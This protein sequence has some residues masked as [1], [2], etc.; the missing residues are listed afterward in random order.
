MNICKNTTRKIFKKNKIVK[1]IAL[2]L[3]VSAGFNL[4]I[5]SATT[6]V[7]NDDWLHVE[8]NQILDQQGNKVWLTGANWLVYGL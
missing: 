2:A 4:S 7:A 1:N 5:A 3:L 6:A 8:G